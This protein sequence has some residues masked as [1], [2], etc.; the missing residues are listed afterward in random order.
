VNKRATET[1]SFFDRWVWYIANGKNVTVDSLSA[2][3]TNHP[4]NIDYQVRKF[5]VGLQSKA[6]HKR[7]GILPH[8][9]CDDTA[10]HTLGVALTTLKVLGHHDL[11]TQF[12][13]P[14]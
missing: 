9:W 1:A 10:G 2:L 14:L 3:R 6:T 4:E 5:A 7:F 8:Q 12:R 13:I 11:A